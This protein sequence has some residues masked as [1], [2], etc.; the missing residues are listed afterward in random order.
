M[1]LIK[2]FRNTGC[3]NETT[4]VSGERKIDN[5]HTDRLRSWRQTQQWALPICLTHERPSGHV[6]ATN[7]YID[8]MQYSASFVWC[9]AFH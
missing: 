8:V 1:T 4:R 9:D 2:V 6:T 7:S 3:Y 5:L